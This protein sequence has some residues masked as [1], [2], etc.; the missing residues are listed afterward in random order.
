[1]VKELIERYQSYSDM[2]LMNIYNNKQGYTEDAKKA[3]DIVIE[4]KGGIKSL[5]QRHQNFIEA[6]EAKENLKND[7][8]KLNSENLSKDEILTRVASNNLSNTQQMEIFNRTFQQIE[9]EE[10]DTE[11]RSKT[12][13][14]SIIGG[15][16]G[17]TTGGILWALQLIYS[18]HIFYIFGFGLVV[19]SY[20]AIK[21]FTKQSKNNLVVFS[22]TILSVI[23]ALILGFYLYDLIG[24][25]GYNRL[26]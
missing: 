19:L 26:N 7:I 17:G 20:G 11:I 18:A 8:I 12:I 9:D 1:M 5:Q 2:E 16:I 21:L 23:Y 4:E 25:R 3:L 10:K 24:Y 6:E 14:D 15:L 13:V 22:M